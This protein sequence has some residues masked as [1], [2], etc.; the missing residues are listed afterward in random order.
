MNSDDFEKRIQRQSLRQIPREW[1]EEI[2]Q[3]AR[4]VSTADPSAKRPAVFA[5]LS[6]YFWTLLR[7]HPK[8][9]ATLAAVWITIVAMNFYC[10]DKTTARAQKV[11]PPTR[12]MILVLQNQRRELA[13]LI[14]P[15]DS[16]DADKPKISQPRP[17]SERRFENSMV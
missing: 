15:V 13:K 8:T 11:S 16:G 2:L 5:N 17:R 9:W 7:L 1:R 14:P 6:S 3:A 10:A 4:A 12:E